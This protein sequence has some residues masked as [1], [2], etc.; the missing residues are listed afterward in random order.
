MDLG[1][2]AKIAN[3][4]AANEMLIVMPHP[5]SAAVFGFKNVGGVWLGLVID[6]GDAVRG[7]PDTEIGATDVLD[8]PVDLNDVR[9]ALKQR[10]LADRRN[11]VGA[12]ARSPV[13]PDDERAV[14]SINLADAKGAAITALKH[15]LVLAGPGI[16]DRVGRVTGLKSE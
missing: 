5:V 2:E 10:D 3:D 4:R 1:I 15:E 12:V 8:L 11:C 6:I 13:I 7:I 9:V 14:A 16:A